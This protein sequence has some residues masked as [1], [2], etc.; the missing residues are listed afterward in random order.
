MTNKQTRNRAVNSAGGFIRDFKAFLMRGN[1]VDLA[2]AV[3]IGVAFNAVVQSFI[4]D[5][6]TPIILS[7]ALDAAGVEN[8]SQLS[9]NGIQYGLFLAAV[10]N[11]VVIAFVI[12]LVIRAFEKMKRKEAVEA[13]ESSA[14]PT[15]EE[16]LNDTLTQLT[17]VMN[18]KL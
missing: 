8:I 13:A 12:F 6:I 10:I 15:I 7:P 11:F 5:L 18:R 2:V 9:F 14:E 1:V 4:A 16:K 17:D 3:I